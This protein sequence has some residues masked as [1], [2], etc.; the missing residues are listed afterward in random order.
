LTDIDTTRRN[1]GFSLADYFFTYI[2]CP[3]SLNA[4]SIRRFCP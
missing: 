3:T 2:Y 4:E 1:R